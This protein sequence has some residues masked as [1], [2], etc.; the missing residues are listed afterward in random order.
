MSHLKGAGFVGIFTGKI[1]VH[2]ETVY[3]IQLIMYQIDNKD[4]FDY[5][6]QIH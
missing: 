3:Q 6:V 5:S 2:N 1:N 4:L